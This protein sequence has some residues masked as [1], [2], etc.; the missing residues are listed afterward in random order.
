[1]LLWQGA[2]YLVRRRD[3]EDVIVS[4]GLRGFLSKFVVPSLP[5]GFY[6]TASYNRARGELVIVGGRP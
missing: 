1:M 6:G 5:A 4:G 3:A 2:L